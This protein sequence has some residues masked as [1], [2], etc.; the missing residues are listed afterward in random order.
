MGDE[1]PLTQ[2]KFSPDA[3]LFC[4]SSWFGPRVASYGPVKMAHFNGLMDCESQLNPLRIPKGPASSSFG[5]R[6]PVIRCSPF[7]DTKIGGAWRKSQRESLT[8]SFLMQKTQVF[9]GVLHYSTQVSCIIHHHL[10]LPPST[11]RHC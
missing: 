4:T 7:V 3:Q 6:H 9:R 5:R 10:P 8:R 11:V 1:R 2:G